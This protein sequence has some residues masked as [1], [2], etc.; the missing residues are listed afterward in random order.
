MK[1][2]DDIVVGSGV[3]GL[4]TALNLYIPIQLY[5]EGITFTVCKALPCSKKVSSLLIWQF[6]DHPQ[7]ST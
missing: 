1:K 6:P 7:A 2:Y 3:S 4:T 5:I